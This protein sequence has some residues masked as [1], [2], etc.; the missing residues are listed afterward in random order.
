MTLKPLL[1]AGAL[2]ALAAPAMATAATPAKVIDCHTYSDFPNTQI[3]SAR[4][5]TCQAAVTVMKAYRGDISRKF[6][7]PQGFTCRQASGS[8]YGGQWRCTKGAKAFRFE[9]KD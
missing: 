1:L 2:L 9:F 7:A 8:Q 6:K 5:M 3:S 4:G